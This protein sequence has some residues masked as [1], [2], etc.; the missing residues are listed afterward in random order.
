MATFLSCNIV[1]ECG[2]NKRFNGLDRHCSLLLTELFKNA[3]STNVSAVYTATASVVCTTDVSVICLTT[4]LCFLLKN[5][6]PRLLYY[7]ATA[8]LLTNSLFI[9]KTFDVPFPLY[10]FIKIAQVFTNEIK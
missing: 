8:R 10:S 3:L 4:A 7:T 9:D 5:F 6:R 2:F 1:H